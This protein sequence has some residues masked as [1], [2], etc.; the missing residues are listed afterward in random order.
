[1]DK[2][3]HSDSDIRPMPVYGIERWLITITVMLVAIIEVLDMTIVNVALP[4]MMG[5]LGTNTN[6]ITWVLT[7]YIVSSAIFMPLT[8]FL[9]TRFGTKNLLSINII[10]FLIASMCCGLANSLTTIVFFRA[11]QGIFGAALVP[12]SQYVL[13]DTFSEKEQGMAMAIWG[14]G[15]MVAP[16]MGPTLGGYITEHLTWRWV[17]YI[18]IPVCITAFIMARRVMRASVTKTVKIDWLGMGLMGIGIGTLQIFLDKGNEQGWFSSD[19]I[20][21]LALIFVFCL[22]V[23]IIR[24]LIIKEK[25]I[26]NLLLFKDRNFAACTLTMALFGI[27]LFGTM[28]LIPIQLEHLMHYPV[29]LTGLLTIPQG[30]AT[31]V[32]MIIIGPFITKIDARKIIFLGILLAALGTFRLST[33]NLYTNMQVSLIV[34]LIIQGIG[35]GMFFIPLAALAL[36]TLPSHQTAEASGI[37]SFS[38]NLGS[39]IGIS[40]ISTVL[41]HETQ[42][43][44]HDIG[45]HLKY[46]NTNLHVWLHA[47]HLLI[48]NPKATILL[49]KSLAAQSAMNAFNDAYWFVT[50]IFLFMLPV[51][52]I[53][54][55]PNFTDKQVI[56]AH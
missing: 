6:Q 11:C 39:S 10:G 4:R 54:K 33:L 56:T 24:G 28:S 36:L 7:S 19:I 52:F 49:S 50:L 37:F 1:M 13:R 15:M 16:I 29:L 32:T 47:H 41:S 23:F 44:W 34:P 30:I 2:V 8:G 5:S 27:G 43:N 55:K 25:N 40:F 53:I 46:N 35:M 12:I 45:G 31:A 51:V 38:R 9:V 3:T 17:F 14:M 22:T 21:I 48:N 26:I 42:V 20:I 18:N